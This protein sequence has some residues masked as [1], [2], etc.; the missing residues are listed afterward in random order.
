MNFSTVDLQVLALDQEPGHLVP[1]PFHE[2]G[3]GRPGNL[4]FIGRVV[5]I[6]AVIV[7]Q[8]DGLEFI[9]G[10]FKTFQ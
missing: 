9:E 6:L 10:Q 8:P 3:E 4:H 1:G 2:T 5:V 7:R